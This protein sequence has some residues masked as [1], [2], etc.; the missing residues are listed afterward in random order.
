MGSIKRK[1][2]ISVP[3]PSAMRKGATAVA[4]ATRNVL[5]EGGGDGSLVGGK[6]QAPVYLTTPFLFH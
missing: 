2:I 1:K 5:R 4:A 6:Q 3:L